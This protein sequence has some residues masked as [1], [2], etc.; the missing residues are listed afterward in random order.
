M[1]TSNGRRVYPRESDGHL[2]LQ[3]GDYG[4]DAEGMWHARPP[5][6]SHG[7]ALIDHKVIEHEDGTITVSPSLVLYPANNGKIPGYHGYLERGVWREV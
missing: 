5:N 4:K 2:Y 1:T 3:P 7:G 6:G